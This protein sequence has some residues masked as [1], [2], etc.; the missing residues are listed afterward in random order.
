MNGSALLFGIGLARKAG[1]L[2]SG[3]DMVLDEVR[4]HGTQTLVVAA[5]DLSAASLKKI[6]DHCT[7][8]HAELFVC[9]AGKEKIGA[10]IGKPFAAC[11]CVSDAN[12]AALWKRNFTNTERKD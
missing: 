1:K 12:F 8:Y 7:Y 10:A 5:N 6:K 3:T 9:D 2:T 4:R 11:V